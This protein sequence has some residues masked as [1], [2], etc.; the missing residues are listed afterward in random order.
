M[1][2]PKDI[3]DLE[4]LSEYFKIGLHRFEF[5]RACI[6]GYKSQLF[7]LKNK[8]TGMYLAYDGVN[9]LYEVWETKAHKFTQQEIGSMNTGSYEQ[10]EVTE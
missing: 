7:Y 4:K 5:E 9:D 1:N 10:I 6:I 8:L 3:L 2:L